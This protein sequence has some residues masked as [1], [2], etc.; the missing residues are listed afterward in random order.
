MPA[1]RVGHFMCFDLAE[2]TLHISTKLKVP[3]YG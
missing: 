1:N 3:A 2:V